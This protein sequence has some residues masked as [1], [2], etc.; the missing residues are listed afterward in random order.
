MKDTGKKGAKGKRPA[1]ASRAAARPAPT[2]HLQQTREPAGGRDTGPDAD[3]YTI[4]LSEPH[5]VAE[6]FS[7]LDDPNEAAHSRQW[8]RWQADNLMLATSTTPA[9]GSGMRDA[10]PEGFKL[11]AAAVEN[12]APP[13]EMLGEH[14]FRLYDVIARV[15]SRVRR[16]VP[17]AEAHADLDDREQPQ[18]Y[19]LAASFKVHDAT[20]YDFTEE[21]IKKLAQDL[22]DSRHQGEGEE[23]AILLLT[24]LYGVAEE[25]NRQRRRDFVHYVERQ[26][27]TEVGEAYAVVSTL[28]IERARAARQEGGAR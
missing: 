5:V 20:L 8:L 24:M 3:R 12:N 22:I 11:N 25:E 1:R 2:T 21:Q 19:T 9:T 14:F 6:L 28:V 16:G 15:L 13:D 10:T 26:L 18:T 17:L 4:T 23:T 7:L 27:L